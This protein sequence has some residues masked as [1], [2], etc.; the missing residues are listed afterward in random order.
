MLRWDMAKNKLGTTDLDCTFMFLQL[1]QD[2]F[3][4][5]RVVQRPILATLSELVSTK[6][7]HTGCWMDRT[8]FVG[9]HKKRR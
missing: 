3:V 1:E 2:N 6:S 7:L 8:T 4:S 5:N 9:I